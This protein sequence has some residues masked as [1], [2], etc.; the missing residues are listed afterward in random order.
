MNPIAT[1]VV[2]YRYHQYQVLSSTQY[3]STILCPWVRWTDSH[4]CP[5][6]AARTD[7]LLVALLCILHDTASGNPAF[8]PVKAAAQILNDLHDF[9]PNTPLCTW[10]DPQ[11]WTHKAA[12]NVSPPP[13]LR[14]PSN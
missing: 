12:P 10:L 2:G 1:A 5:Q 3:Y 7:C 14:K 9:P 11:G 4:L 8:C 6:Q 13:T